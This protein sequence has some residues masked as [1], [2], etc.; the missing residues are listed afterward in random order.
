MPT[1]TGKPLILGP[2]PE[3]KPFVINKENRNAT[4]VKEL[5]REDVNGMFLFYFY[6]NGEGNGEGFLLPPGLSNEETRLFQQEFLAMFNRY[7]KLANR[8]K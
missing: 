5:L 4:M 6:K 3:K 8:R 1:F 7:A 2:I